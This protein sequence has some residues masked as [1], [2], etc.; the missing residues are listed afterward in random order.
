MYTHS[1]KQLGENGIYSIAQNIKYISNLQFL[2]LGIYTYTD[3]YK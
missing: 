3:I 2:D 1:V